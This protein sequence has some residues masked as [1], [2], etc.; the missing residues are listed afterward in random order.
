MNVD[1]TYAVIYS[2]GACHPNPGKGGW[3]CIIKWNGKEKIVTGIEEYSTNNRME[4]MGLK[5]CLPLL[6]MN[7]IKTMK[8][9]SDSKYLGYGLKWTGKKRKKL[10]REDLPNK[11]L[12]VN[13]HNSLEKYGI[14]I[15]FEWVKGHAGHIE[16][17]RCDSMAENLIRN[18]MSYA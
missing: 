9:V 4:I 15:E 1:K 7:G 17:E 3:C 5:E 13:I 6:G 8:V 10:L 14:E 12:W 16:N 2:D 11:E 18:T